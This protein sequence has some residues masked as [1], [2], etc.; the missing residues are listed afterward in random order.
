M[1]TNQFF[2]K[3]GRFPLKKI[4][5]LI[6]LNNLTQSNYE[7]YDIKDL[8][9]ATKKDITFLS[10]IN[11]KDVS[12]KT[13]ALACVTTES[14]SKYLPNYCIKIIVKN[15]LFSV[16]KISKLFYPTAEVDQPDINLK[17]ISDLS[18]IY[19]D[20]LFGKNILIG[21]NV[22]IG[23]FSKISSNTIIESNVEIGSNCNIGAFVLI[24]NSIIENN[25]CISEGTI[26][27]KKGFGFI[28]F[29]EN[30][31]KSPQIGKV[32]IKEGAEIGS[33]CNIDRGSMSD[34]IIGS[35]TFLDD[36][37]K[38]AHNVKI[39]KNCILAGQS[40]VAGSTIIGDNVAIGGKVGIS[41]HLKIGNNVK[42]AGGSGVTKNVPDN[43]KIMGY[44]AVPIKDF[45]KQK[46]Q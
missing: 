4:L 7:V 21:S 27:G 30:N 16:T 6:N 25:V 22:K 35:N 39:G 8:V 18:N 5:D 10:S 36:K 20:V 29:P 24:R 23:K 31:L 38:I 9:A 3:K 34:T 33:N 17:D 15:V 19:T 11:Y 2:K 28:P 12:I 26:I 44:P 41:G 42:I 13:K 37:I 1:V 14:L 40:G 45:I 32:I 43:T 46:K